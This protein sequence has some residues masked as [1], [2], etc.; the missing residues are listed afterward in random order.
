VTVERIKAMLDERPF[1]PF[2]IHTSDG[3]VVTVKAPDFAWIHPKGRTMYVCP[4]PNVDADEVIDL[5]HVTKL[6]S[7]KRT[8]RNGGGGSRRR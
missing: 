8:G 5:L 2:E 3:K 7:R 4:D 6:A 1:R